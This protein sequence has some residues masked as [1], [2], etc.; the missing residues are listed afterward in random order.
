M[1]K[2]KKGHSGYKPLGA[3]S[4]KTLA[5]EH[6]G[7]FITEAGAERV[8]SILGTC[9]PDKFMIYY[10]MLLEYF[11]PKLARVDNLQLPENTPALTKIEIV[12]STKS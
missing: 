10:P 9:P 6:L 7:E 3:K 5:W 11:K 12:D 4:E 8:K 1:A 2:F